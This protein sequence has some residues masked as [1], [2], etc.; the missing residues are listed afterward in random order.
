MK[1]LALSIVILLV[2]TA[3]GGT[4]EPLPDSVADE[5]SMPDDVLGELEI[6]EV[7]GDFEPIVWIEESDVQR[8]LDE[9]PEQTGILWGGVRYSE[10][11]LSVPMNYSY[12][13]GEL[14]LERGNDSPERR[15][16]I[17]AHFRE[18]GEI[19]GGRI[20]S[21]E[22]AAHYANRI[23]AYI[24]EIDTGSGVFELSQVDYDPNQNIWVF[25]YSPN[26]IGL[27]GDACW[28]AVN[29]ENAD[30]IRIWWD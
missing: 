16:E 4:S 13:G 5:T 7:F 9:L 8:L 12:D 11:D 2:L 20:E 15:D 30:L 19:R 28:V 14:R 3:C 24:G 17:N 22:A 10:V 29:G 18:S 25:G 26:I 23:L 1:K 6:F 27:L 21:R